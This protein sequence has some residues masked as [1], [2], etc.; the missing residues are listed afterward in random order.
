M[1]TGVAGRTGGEAAGGAR[2]RVACVFAEQVQLLYSGARDASV[3]T[4]LN[5]LLLAY[6]QRSV[7]AFPILLSWAA[8]MVL[9][10]LGRAGLAY[11]YWRA[12][13]RITA[14]SAWNRRYVAGTALLGSGWGLAGVLLFPADSVVHQIFLLFVLA[15]MSAGS[16]AL[17]PVSKVAFLSFLLPAL[18]PSTVRL[19]TLGDDVHLV[20]GGMAVFYLAAVWVSGER[21]HRTIMASL[22]LRHENVDLIAYLTSAKEQAE[23]LNRDLKAEIDQRVRAEA[24]LRKSEEQL[25]HSQKLE[26]VGKLAGGV[27]HEFNNL[28]QV[29]KGYCYFVLS[30]LAPQALMRR[31]IEGIEQATERAADLTNQLLAFSRRQIIMPRVLDLNAVIMEQHRMLNRLIGDDIELGLNLAPELGRVKADPAQVGQVLLNL[32]NNAR[33][34]MAGRGVLTIETANLGLEGAA[35]EEHPGIPRGNFVTVTVRDTGCGIPPEILDRIFEPFFTTKDVG[36]GTG[37][38]LSTVYGLVTQIGGYVR[39]VSHVGKG[40]VFTIYLPMIENAIPQVEPVPAAAGS[41]AGVETVLLVEDER[42]VREILRATLESQG[43]RVLEGQDGAE[44]MHVCRDHAGPI[45]VLATDLVMPGMGGRELAQHVLQ[46]NPEAVV[47]YI[48]GYTDDRPDLE[49]SPGIV[50]AFLRKPFSP[51]MFLRKVRE[52]LDAR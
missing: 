49:D 29:I 13:D 33:D 16:V 18:I 11:R 31:D 35:Q 9:L 6:V 23:Q 19:L 21:M 50:S 28:L 46:R 25:L 52:L 17:L 36:K 5:V 48:S 45:H 47:L 38:G 32:V 1:S 51:E 30:G 26:A 7:I 22:T 40:S 8:G 43:Y 12:P 3:A 15:G 27:A 39:A 37:L 34:A 42:E 14:A 20:M 4:I 24:A 2:H 44:A 41:L 10:T